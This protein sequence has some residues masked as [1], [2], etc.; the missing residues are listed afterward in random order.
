M[1]RSQLLFICLWEL[2]AEWAAESTMPLLNWFLSSVKRTGN[3][4]NREWSC[5][6]MFHYLYIFNLLV[7]VTRIWLLIKVGFC[8]CFVSLHYLKIAIER[9]GHLPVHTT[10]LFT[11]SWMFAWGSAAE[12]SCPV[13]VCLE[14]RDYH[15]HFHQS[16]L[17]PKSANFGDTVLPGE[18]G[19]QAKSWRLHSDGAS[20]CSI[21]RHIKKQSCISV[22]L[23]LFFLHVGSEPIRSRTGKSGTSTP[24]TPGSTAITPGTPPSYSSR[25]PGTPG[26]PS[27]SR[28]PHTP[29]TPKS[30]ILVPTEKKV[31][32]I[33]TPPKSPATPK[34][35]RVINQP[36]PDLKNVRSK[37]GS[38]DNIKYQPKGGQVRILV[39]L[40]IHMLFSLTCA[41]S[42]W[43][44]DGSHF[45]F[46]HKCSLSDIKLQGSGLSSEKLS[47]QLKTSSAS[48]RSGEKFQTRDGT[49]CHKY[50]LAWVRAIVASLIFIDT[51]KIRRLALIHASSAS[52]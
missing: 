3:A 8:S 51:R 1:A 28:T 42:G 37:I 24:T 50:V 2:P 15:Q 48:L 43:V 27:Y 47:C 33:R 35:L 39:F 12:S 46:P 30:A 9:E 11:I 4:I 22:S 34:Q 17:T 18:S 5:Y 16:G 41:P 49:P 19:C 25:T 26:T 44:W 23:M 52:T 14:F 40:F 31:A 20:G 36:L 7:N 13:V 21:R 29:G 6:K 38:T 32:I 45:E 10:D